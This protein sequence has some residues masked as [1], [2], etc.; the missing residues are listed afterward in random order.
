MNHKQIACL[1]LLMII[2]AVT[3]F[4]QIVHK[5]V[6]A[7]KRSAEE[8]QSNSVMAEGARQTA[9]IQTT[10]AKAETEEL[11]RFLQSWTPHIDKAQTEQEVESAIEL[12]LRERGINLVRSRK[13]EV[14]PVR[15]NKIIPR[16]VLTTIVV[17]DDYA[18]VMNWMGDV[19]RRLPLARIKACQITG[20][21]TARM[22]QLDISLETPLINLAD[23]ADVKAG[24]KKKS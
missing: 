22:L 8:A 10:R 7:M 15:D 12:S 18:K 14:K 13:T 5:K 11:R 1:F 19:E 6:G 4:G 20:G 17:E 21:G 16:T 9:E 2:G 23:G 3:Y 24:E